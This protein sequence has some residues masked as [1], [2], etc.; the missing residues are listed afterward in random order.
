[1]YKIWNIEVPKTNLIDL[2]SS[3]E[4]TYPNITLEEQKDIHKT[5]ESLIPQSMDFIL[6]INEEKDFSK[7]ILLAVKKDQQI[8]LLWP[9]WTGK[10]TAIYN[11]ANKTNNPLVSI[12][13]TWGTGIDTLIGKWL[14]NKDGTYWIDWLFTMAWKYWFRIIL[15]EINMASADILA[16]L[17]SALDERKVL[18]LEDKNGEVIHRHPNTRIFA[19][20]NPTEDYVGTKEMNQ[21]FID[22]FAW[23]IIID[24]PEQEKEI[25]IIL[26]NKKVEIDNIIPPRTEEWVITRMVK[27]ADSLRKLHKKSE[28][29]FEIS[30]RN[31]IDW[32]CRCSD[33]WIKESFELSILSKADKDDHKKMM[34]EVNKYF[35][36]WDK[37]IANGK[38]E[39][40]QINKKANKGI[41]YT[42]S[43]DDD[44]LDEII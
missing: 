14:I 32:A 43:L 34:D 40:K 17:H 44:M 7:T 13:L 37:W 16:V 30:T 9:K 24:Y 15:D 28:L 1:M 21:A 26:A 19:S 31:L 23:Q 29:I 36:D 33:L 41:E 3:Y 39:V 18:I 22:R 12:Q 27:V 8:L 42:A 35:K 11:L 10:T 4:K 38:S 6:D 5:A 20:M 2:I 25:A